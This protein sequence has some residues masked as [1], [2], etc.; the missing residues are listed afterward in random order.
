MPHPH[1][2]LWYL[3][4]PIGLWLAAAPAHGQ[5]QRFI[6][7][8]CPD[9]SPV[10]E[11]ELN[12]LLRDARTRMD[13]DRVLRRTF[14]RGPMDG[15]YY[16]EVLGDGRIQ[17]LIFYPPSGGSAATAL[18]TLGT[19][20]VYAGPLRD[21]A[22][23]HALFTDSLAVLGELEL[24]LGA[25]FPADMAEAYFLFWSQPGGDDFRRVELPLRDGLLRI[26]RALFNDLGGE[27]VEVVLRN[28]T[29]PGEVLGHAV[30]RFV[31]PT[32][33]RNLSVMV[34]KAT[35]LGGTLAQQRAECVRLL[36]EWYGRVYPPNA[37]RAHCTDR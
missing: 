13:A 5:A 34:C 37:L 28:R 18:R 11:T 15:V 35:P 4:L 7:D 9:G 14:A 8:I 16:H 31:P 24:A 27:R 12:A 19:R 1:C 36:G 22:E 20:D 30:L 26:D 25:S 21:T 6:A 23:L 10:T 32:V 2:C 29:R 17:N 3:L 33:E